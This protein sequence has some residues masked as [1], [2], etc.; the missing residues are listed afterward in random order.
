[1][2]LRRHVGM[3]AATLALVLSYATPAFAADTAP[4]P[5]PVVAT[6]PAATAPTPEPVA[7]EATAPVP[8]ETA[9]PAVAKATTPA[10]VATETTQTPA[11]VSA[12]PTTSASSLPEPT[13]SA[14]EPITPAPERTAVE[15]APQPS[16][17]AAPAAQ[18]ASAQPSTSAPKPAATVSPLLYHEAAITAV[19]NGD[20]TELTV[21]VLSADQRAVKFFASVF[22]AEGG[23]DSE[24]VPLTTTPASVTLPIKPGMDQWGV[25]ISDGDKLI[26][27]ESGAIA[28][29]A[30]QPPMPKPIVTFKQLRCAPAGTAVP[31][32][33][34]IT[35]P[36]TAAPVDVELDIVSFTAKGDPLGHNGVITMQPGET[37]R[38]MTVQGVVGF[39]VNAE[40][41]FSIGDNISQVVTTYDVDDACGEITAAVVNGGVRCTGNGM[42]QVNL[43]VRN[44]ADSVG[45]SLTY[46]VTVTTDT[47]SKVV[48]TVKVADG[49][50]ARMRFD[51]RAGTVDVDVLTVETGGHVRGGMDPL[52]CQPQ[53]KPVVPKPH[54][55]K[56]G[57]PAKPKP[58]HPG[59]AKPA[60]EH[61]KLAE[62]GGT[63]AGIVVLGLGVLAAGAAL[64][65]SRRSPRVG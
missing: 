12:V 43:A 47:G 41:V 30:T 8:H 29:R 25:Q 7:P 51:V 59:Q 15:P 36:T 27:M 26:Q 24:V 5:E 64:S 6:P 44:P 57:T 18:P 28:C 35:K 39:E 2:S 13:A 4:S 1:M 63:D 14:P 33:V 56:P 54:A 45:R 21:T 52:Q 53:V 55:T 46:R 48:R 9:R 16:L 22:G 62:T 17:A 65:A 32:A 10:P 40:V 11:A 49:A 19:P 23:V 61:S 34:T 60:P 50:T 37:S 58:H 3:A 20:C 42:A 31:V 38:T